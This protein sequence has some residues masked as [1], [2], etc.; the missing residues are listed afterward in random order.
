MTTIVEG[1]R[2]FMLADATIA[3]LVGTRVYPN[4]LPQ[5]PTV[6]AI[7]YQFISG[8]DDVTTDGPSGLA[9]PTIQIDCWATTYAA[10]DGLFQAVRKR[11]NGYSGLAGTIAVH[12]VFLV[13]KRDLYDN[14]TK[15]HRRTADWS[16]WHEEALT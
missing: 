12:G 5:S 3:G 4:I 11:I 6:P 14:D 8:T 16:I 7:S 9:N 2:T 1:L 13:R 15:L 10:M